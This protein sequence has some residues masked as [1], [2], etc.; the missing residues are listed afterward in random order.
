MKYVTDFQEYQ[1]LDMADKMKL[2]SWNHVTL[3][4]PDPQVIWPEKQF[5]QLWKNIDAIYERSNTGGGAWTVKNKNLPSSWII[6]Y[7]DLKF[8]L[9]RMGFKHTGLFPEQAYNWNFLRETI[10][11]AKRPVKVL[12]LF[13]YTGAA[14]IAALKEGAE[15]THVDSSRGMVDWAKENM[16]LNHLEN[17]PI[18]FLV[19][20]VN[21]FVKREIRR[22]N[23]Y[24]IILM[25]PPSFGRGSKNEI[26]NIEE[27]LYNLVASCTQLLSQN[28]LLFLINSYST[29]LSKTVLENILYLT[30]N[31]EH[32]GTIVS[33]EL[34]LPLKDS[35]LILPCGLFARWEN[36]K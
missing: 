3:L 20:D 29:G 23:H 36:K 10:R 25:D 16:K 35:S 11:N 19:D 32:P 33:D 17:K 7:R 13:A 9:K 5:P 2:E 34:G 28:P 31:K 27:D 21:K 15:V 4:R 30:V 12:N 22:G 8:N 14:S 24:D 26:W 1:I 6:S 18:R